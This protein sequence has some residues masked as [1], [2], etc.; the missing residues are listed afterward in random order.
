MK[1][2]K[3][4][5]EV[6]GIGLMTGVPSVVELCP[7]DKKGIRFH[8][9]DTVLEAS[10]FNIVSTE[11]CVVLG[12]FSNIQGYKV[13]LIEHFMASVAICGIDA[14]DIVF[15]NPNFEVAKMMQNAFEMPILDGSAKV[16]VEKFNEAGFVGEEDGT[17]NLKEPV[18]YQNEKSA[19]ILLPSEYDT[20][21]TYCV[22]YNHPDLTQRFVTSENLDDVVEART[23]GYLKDLDKLQAAGF[24]RGV[25]IDNTVGLKDVGYTTDL[26]SDLEP[27]KHKILDIIGDLRLTGVNPL[28]AK[29]N[30]IVKE[31]GHF[32]HVETAKILKEK[33]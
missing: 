25:T 3:S 7:S 19:V 12:D 13:A 2:L 1:T 5:I 32:M 23:F 21:I 29:M 33:L 8:I 17:P 31:A 20:K 30:V 14:L 16:W 24:S 18:Y 6:Q 9:A 26:R 11:H 28:K 4:K 27:A 10:P 22:S 15:K